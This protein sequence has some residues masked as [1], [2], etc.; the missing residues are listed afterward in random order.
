MIKNILFILSFLRTTICTSQIKKDT[1]FLKINFNADA[2][3]R[4]NYLN[5]TDTVILS[6]QFLNFFPR[7]YIEAPQ[8]KFMAMEPNSLI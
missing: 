2:T 6:S 4:L 8:N 1:N 3:I 5:F 7:D